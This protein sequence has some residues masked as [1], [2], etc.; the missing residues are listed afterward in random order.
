MT[1]TEAQTSSRS[2]TTLTTPSEREIVMTRVFDAPR[3][4]VFQAFSD[5]QAIPRWW[6]PRRATTVVDQ[7]DV[8]PGGAW[9]FVQRDPEGN[10]Y[11]F[12]GE[13]R[14]ITPP[15]RVVQT[16]EFEGFPGHVSVETLVLEDLGG[17]T[18][19]TASSLFSSVEERDMMLQSGMEGG[20]VETW[21]RMAELLEALQRR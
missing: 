2:P 11:A 17:K 1:T 4:L 7:M 21:D 15:E 14:E 3:D 8:R 10:E 6:G 12:R 9:R 19:V 16:F 18:R 13:Y 5:P 20:A